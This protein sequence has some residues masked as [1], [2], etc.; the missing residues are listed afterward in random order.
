MDLGGQSLV[1]RTTIA[2]E[3][4]DNSD[5]DLIG[6]EVL[7]CIRHEEPF[8]YLD[9]AGQMDRTDTG[10]RAYGGKH[11]VELAETAVA[12]FDDDRARPADQR[13]QNCVGEAGNPVRDRG[14]CALDV[15]HRVDQ[16]FVARETGVPR[17]HD[18]DTF[19]VD[20]VAHPL[21]GE[22]ARDSQGAGKVENA[23]TAVRLQRSNQ[24]GIE[25]AEV[26]LSVSVLRG[27]HGEGLSLFYC[28]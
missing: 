11:L 26:P 4:R 24:S 7:A 16:D 2:L 18:F 6:R 1:A 10:D 3:H 14:S 9:I 19:V 27:R 15:E 12:E 13:D 8:E 21:R 25:V 17:G 23:D 5:V 22:I 20:E 28:V